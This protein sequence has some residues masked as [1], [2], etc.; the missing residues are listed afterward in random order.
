VYGV[1]V[2][3][4]IEVFEQQKIIYLIEEINIQI[5]N[6]IRFKV[7]IVRAELH[8]L[9]ILLVPYFLIKLSNVGGKTI[10]DNYE[11][12]QMLILRLLCKF[13]D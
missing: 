1:G 2:M 13:L 7:L 9:V 4:H 5:I 10:N 3:M 12:E 11:I 8:W 6:N